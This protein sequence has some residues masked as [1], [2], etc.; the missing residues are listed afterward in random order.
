MGPCTVF[1]LMMMLCTAAL[2]SSSDCPWG[3]RRGGGIVTKEIPRNY[4]ICYPFRS[5]LTYIHT[6]IHIKGATLRS[7]TSC[8][9]TYLLNILPNYLPL[10]G[11]YLHLH[12]SVPV[13]TVVI[14]PVDHCRSLTYLPTYLPIP[15]LFADTEYL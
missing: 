7:P 13:C 10:R 14:A 9:N 15:Y 2:R 6:Y 4:R 12:H 3:E 1:R 11:Y 5:R 8:G